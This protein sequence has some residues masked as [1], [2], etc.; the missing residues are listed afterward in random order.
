[1][2]VSGFLMLQLHSAEEGRG[3][4][5]AWVVYGQKGKSRSHSDSSNLS[6]V[7]PRQ[8]KS[9]L[10]PRGYGM[11]HTRGKKLCP[12]PKTIPLPLWSWWS[13]IEKSKVEKQ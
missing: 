9:S 1:M 3:K 12:P 13:W 2:E 8:T 7:L 5:E 6:P 10:C 4:D 11:A